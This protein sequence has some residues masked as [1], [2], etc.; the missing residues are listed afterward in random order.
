MSNL[1]EILMPTEHQEGTKALIGTWLKKVGDPVKENEPI[2]ELSTDKV[3]VEIASPATGTLHEILK[4]PNEKVEPGEVL[5]RITRGAAAA[6]VQELQPAKA[7]VVS[8]SPQKSAPTTKR[9]DLT[10]AV[11]AFLAE[12]KIS[13]TTLATHSIVGSGA[14]G[15][16]TL[17]DLQQNRAA[18][19]KGS[20][21]PAPTATPS[22]ENRSVPH[23]PMRKV[24]AEHM[25]ESLLHTAPHVTTIFHCDC[26]AILAHREQHKA[27]FQAEGLRLTLTS[28]FVLATVSALRAVPEVNSR[29]HD[30]RL[31]IF[32]E[33]HLGIAT[34]IDGGAGQDAGLIV[35]VLRNAERLTLRD[36]ARSLEELTTKA[37]SG[38][39]SRAEVQGATF[40]ISN[41]GVSGSLVATPI[42]I[43]QPQSAILG[44]G[45]L[46][47]RV[48]VR[49]VEGHDTIQIRPMMYVTLTLDHRALDGFK[50]NAFLAAFVQSVERAEFA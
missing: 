42:I 20:G 17:E 39:L 48:V 18:L 1:A 22:S 7:A 23:S 27:A 26:S 32:H 16:I 5:G 47:K 2:V 30:D 8:D 36:V 49:E 12:H 38:K 50:A 6:N 40:S 24:I 46:E 11:K 34:A 10:P 41:H 35:P 4:K 45:K 13:A 21:K 37:R 25:V 19:L 31:E 43:P 3:S 15:R 14:E 9:Q 44:L 28:Y 29:W 33:Q